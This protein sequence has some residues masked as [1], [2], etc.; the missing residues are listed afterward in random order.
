MSDCRMTHATTRP[1]LSPA[2]VAALSDAQGPGLA[3]ARAGWHPCTIGGGYA[4]T[5]RC[6][7]RG[8]VKALAARRYLALAFDRARITEAGQRALIAARVA[9]FEEQAG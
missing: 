5:D 6:H 8:T 3:R 7:A 2:Q 9:Q 1:R 4:A